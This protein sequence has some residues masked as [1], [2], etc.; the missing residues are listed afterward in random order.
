MEHVTVSLASF[1]W[2]HLFGA[3]QERFLLEVFGEAKDSAR[4][5]RVRKRENEKKFNSME[6][7]IQISFSPE[8]ENQKREFNWIERRVERASAPF[9]TTLS[10][11]HFQREIHI[12][13]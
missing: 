5:T 13:I 3:C 8:M 2:I 10:A 1:Y 11:K 7:R 12:A 4:H 6:I 9:H